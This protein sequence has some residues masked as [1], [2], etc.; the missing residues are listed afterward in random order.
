MPLVRIALPAG[1]PPDVAAALSKSVHAALVE[2]FA[3]PADDYF[4]V[5][6]E[7][8]PNAG[9]MG[10]RQ[11]LGIT[12]TP[13]M[14]L[15]QIACSPGRT[16]DQKRALYAAIADRCHAATGLRREDVIINLLETARENWSFGNGL[17][18]YA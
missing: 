15:I 12:H 9:L 18:S 1:K 10:P 16:L 3:V 14:V 17:A 4:Q 13:D 7:H 8:V 11:F 2:T 6:T 5:V